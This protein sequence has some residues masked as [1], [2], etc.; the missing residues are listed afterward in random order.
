MAEEWPNVYR[1]L[2]A[3]KKTGRWTAETRNVA[4]LMERAPPDSGKDD[5]HT[6]RGRG[7]GCRSK[8]RRKQLTYRTDPAKFAKTAA[9]KPAAPALTATKL[10]DHCD[11]ASEASNVA[12]SAPSQAAAVIR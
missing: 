1:D 6:H 10:R 8:S 12:E 5:V 11:V 7:Q 9:P 2:A 4:A 3:A